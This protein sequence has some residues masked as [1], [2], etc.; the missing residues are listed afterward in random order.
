MNHLDDLA[1]MIDCLD[2]T[3]TTSNVTAHFA[4]GLGRRCWLAV[5]KSPL[6]YWGRH[7]D[8][9]LF[10]PTL[11]PFR[12]N[13]VADWSNVVGDLSDA[14]SDSLSDSL[15]QWLGAESEDTKKRER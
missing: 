14:L 12:Q 11:K 7:G 1:A 10:Y 13:K 6:W 8:A 3:I 5:Q 9:P 4:G 2:L 15:G